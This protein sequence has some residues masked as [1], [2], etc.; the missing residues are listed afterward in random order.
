MISV[1]VP[2]WNSAYW[3]GRC[4][5]SL[6]AQKGDMEFILVDD[7]SNDRSKYYA[8]TR[9]DYDDRIKVLGNEHRD[10]VSGARNTGLDHA[11]GEWVT[12]L[13]SD[14]AMLHD[15]FEV[16]ERMQRLDPTA[17]IIQANH[18]RHYAKTGRTVMKYSNDRG[19]YDLRRLPQ[20]WCM[21]WN[22]L[23]RR[24]F[25]ENNNIR[26]VEGLQYGEDEIF[27][28]ELLARDNRIFHTKRNTATITRHFDNKQSL[29]RIKDKRGLIAQAHALESFIMRTDSIEARMAACKLL[30]EHWSSPTY[31]KAFGGTDEA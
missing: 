3:L 24:S 28:L 17:N 16:Y 10:G 21:V 13:D 31:I 22:K 14:D 4:I 9:A 5:D 19:V 27:N 26:F 6:T 29:S 30:S 2:M 18:L 8:L 23:I 25:I 12:F 1:I 20:C 15:A 7:R 11:R